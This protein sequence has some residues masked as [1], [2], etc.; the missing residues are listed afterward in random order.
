MPVMNIVEYLKTSFLKLH[1]LN[2]CH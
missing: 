1:L 2:Q